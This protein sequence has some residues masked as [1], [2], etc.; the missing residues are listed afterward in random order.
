MAHIYGQNLAAAESMSASVAPWGWSPATLKATADL[1][2]LNGINRIVI[3]ESTHQPVVGKKP[4][5]TL[6]PYGQWFNRNETWAEEAKPWIDYLAR[7]SFLLQ[8]GH[9]AAD[10][11]Y[12]YGEDSNLTAIFQSRSPDVPAGYAFDYINADALAHELHVDGGRL[13][14]HSGMRYKV[15][16]LDSYS[17]HMSLPVLEAIRRLVSDGATVVGPRPTDDPSL[18]DDPARFT[19]I[20]DELFGDGSGVHQIGNGTVYAGK[21]LAEVLPTLGIAPDFEAPKGNDATDF[22][23]VH[24]TLPDGEIYFVDNRSDRVASITPLFG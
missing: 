1:E 11:A 24:R 2:F 19:Q 18:A 10:V 16:A 7:C 3:H 12:F 6:G 23:F 14:T 13:V 21:P 4:G 17:Q 9:F 15:L 22:E 5:L 20:A 8:Q